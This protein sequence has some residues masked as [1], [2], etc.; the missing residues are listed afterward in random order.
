MEQHFVK[1]S[2]QKVLVD[3][4]ILQDCCIFVCFKQLYISHEYGL[5]HNTGILGTEPIS[6]IFKRYLIQHCM[7]KSVCKKL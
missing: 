4:D 7:L 5:L 3:C 1:D 2:L 6:L